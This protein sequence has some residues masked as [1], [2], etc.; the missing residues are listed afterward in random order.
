MLLPLFRLRNVVILKRSRGF[1]EVGRRIASVSLARNVYVTMPQILGDFLH[2]NTIVHADARKMPKLA[3]TYVIDPGLF[4]GRFQT[5]LDR[6]HTV[7]GPLNHTVTQ[8]TASDSLDPAATVRWI[9]GA[10]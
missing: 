2:R 8:R 4:C 6:S 9:R 5:S 1:R 10:N 7:T 3:R